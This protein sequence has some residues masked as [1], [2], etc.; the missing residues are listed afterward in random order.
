M[1]YN[2]LRNMSKNLHLF[3]LSC[4]AMRRPEAWRYERGRQEKAD[5]SL[6]LPCGRQVRDDKVSG[7]VAKGYDGSLGRRLASGWRGD[8]SFGGKATCQNVGLGRRNSTPTLTCSL[9]KRSMWAT[10]HSSESLVC[11]FV[12]V[13][14]WPRYGGAEK[15]SSAP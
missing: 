13:S 11:G 2:L 4:Q 6:R 9:G 15:A 7:M 14:R 3:D 1:P 12:S 10:T 8:Q 5:P